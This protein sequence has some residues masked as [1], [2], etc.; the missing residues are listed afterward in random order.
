MSTSFP[1]NSS[2]NT[3][4]Y[5]ACM[6]IVEGLRDSCGGIIL[7]DLSCPGVSPSNPPNSLV[8]DGESLTGIGE[9]LD[10]VCV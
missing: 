8:G 4:S 7:G 6:C 10:G 3:D 1:P 5:L 9:T 2:S